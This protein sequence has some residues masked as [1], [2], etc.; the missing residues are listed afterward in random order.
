MRFD[1]LISS[2]LLTTCTLALACSDDGQSDDEAETST[3]GDST[4]EDGS[5]DDADTTDAETTDAETTDAETTDAETTDAETTDAETTDAETTD[6]ETTDAETTDAETTDAETTDA[7]TTGSLSC[8]E[9]EAEYESLV[10]MTDCQGDDE[11][12]IIAGHC[13]VGLGGCDYAVNVS[14]AVTALDDLAEAY[15]AGNCTNGVCDC[16]PPPASAVCMNGTCVGVD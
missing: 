12:K 14:V 8:S 7:E 5:T 15:V 3:E 16:A 2:L 4:T 13:G 1:S 6:A 10:T 11:C 9:I